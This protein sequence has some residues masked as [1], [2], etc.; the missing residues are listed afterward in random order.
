MVMAQLVVLAGIVLLEA[1]RAFRKFVSAP[2]GPRQTAGERRWRRVGVLLRLIIALGL[3]VAADRGLVWAI[4]VLC[5]V[6]ALKVVRPAQS[7][8]RGVGRRFS[9][10]RK[11][12][13]RS[14]GRVAGAIA[15]L[16]GAGV[17][18]W[19]LLDANPG[20][21]RGWVVAAAGIVV[22]VSL[23]VH[24][25]D[26]LRLVI[27][28]VWEPQTFDSIGPCVHRL[29]VAPIGAVL[30]ISYNKRRILSFERVA[31]S[32]EGPYSIQF[33]LWND[34]RAEHQL[35]KA[36][37]LIGSSGFVTEPGRRTATEAP[38]ECCRVRLSG[39]TDATRTNAR[40]PAEAARVGF[41]LPLFAEIRC[42]LSRNAKRDRWAHHIYV[43]S[44]K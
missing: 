6:I 3:A 38:G 20:I 27:P 5:I 14:A 1:V 35:S 7:L 19:V 17:P 33:V 44:A 10:G 31:P 36:L 12:G 13:G 22:S 2:T 16:V 8:G 39:D 34:G 4:A 26:A 40:T 25:T 18:I 37:E 23:A 42:T 30:S 28:K 29:L 9:S 21:S 11:A 24:R 41:G 43:S 15:L 32:G